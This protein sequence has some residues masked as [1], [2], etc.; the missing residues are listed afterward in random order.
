MPKIIISNISAKT[1]MGIAAWAAR[2]LAARLASLP[3][4]WF[5]IRPKMCG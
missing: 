4:R 1:P 3:D 5:K 2:A